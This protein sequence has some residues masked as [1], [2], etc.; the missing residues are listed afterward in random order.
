MTEWIVTE[1]YGDWNKFPILIS[2][3][4]GIAGATGSVG[5]TVS[6]QTA[7]GELIAKVTVGRKN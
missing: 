4:V 1:A 3:A 5:A 6:E 2:E 7:S